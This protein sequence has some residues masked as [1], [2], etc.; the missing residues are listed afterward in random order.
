MMISKIFNFFD[1]LEDRIRGKLSRH[2]IPY[3]IISG[4]AVVLF[5]RGVWEGSDLLG[6]HP[7]VSLLVGLIGLLATGVLVSEFIG[8]SLIISGLKGEKKIEEREIKDIEQE[9]AVLDKIYRKL[10]KIETEVQG[11]KDQQK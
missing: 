4:I 2:P 6:M 10:D 5:W 1:K 9:E 7:F 3:G 8:K 11:I